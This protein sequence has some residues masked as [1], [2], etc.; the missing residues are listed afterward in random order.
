MDITD[1]LAPAHTICGMKAEDKTRLLAELA[2]RAAGAAHIS[3]PVIEE[4]L[5]AREALGSTGVGAGIAIPHARI[6]GLAR[7]FGLFAQL[8]RRI[9]YD[10]IDDEKVDLVFLLL[11]PMEATSEHLQALACISRRLRDGSVA[12]RLRKATTTQAVY[13][14]LT[15]ALPA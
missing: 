4:A 9:D 10:A 13:K 5:R 6:P 12:A 8:D 2:R 15:E 3:Q 1:L 14:I 11:V 7:F